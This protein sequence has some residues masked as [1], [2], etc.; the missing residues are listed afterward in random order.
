LENAAFVSKFGFIRETLN[1]LLKKHFSSLEKFFQ[2]DEQKPSL[3]AKSEEI[4]GISSFLEILPQ[5]VF[6]FA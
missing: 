4:I 3:P 2:T 5:K 1:S 6:C